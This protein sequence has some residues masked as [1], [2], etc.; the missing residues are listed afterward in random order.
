MRCLIVLRCFSSVQMSNLFLSSPPPP[1]HQPHQPQKFSIMIRTVV[2]NLEWL[3]VFVSLCLQTFQV[4]KITI[5]KFNCQYN[6]LKLMWGLELDYFNSSCA[7][8]T[9]RILITKIGAHF[10]PAISLSFAI[11]RP[12][13]LSPHELAGFKEFLVI[14]IILILLTTRTFWTQKLMC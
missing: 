3:L 13:E 7:C 6:R 1:H 8:T 11:F 10:N 4:R 5:H 2:L 12:N 14:T 9:T